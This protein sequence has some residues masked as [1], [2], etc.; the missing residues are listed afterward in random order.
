MVKPI[1]GLLDGFKYINGKLV[2]GVGPAKGKTQGPELDEI[3]NKQVSDYVDTAKGYESDA[4]WYKESGDE[5]NR[6]YSPN[7][8]ERMSHNIGI[9][10]AQNPLSNN[11]RMAVE[12]ENARQLG[13][14][15]GAGKFKDQIEKTKLINQNKFYTI[16]ANGNKVPVAQGNKIGPFT[17]TLV[18]NTRNSTEKYQGVRNDG[19]NLAQDD[20][21]R[22]VHDIWDIRALGDRKD[23]LTATEHTYAD[24]VTDKAVKLANERKLGGRSDWTREQLQASVWE[25]QRAK[26][27]AKRAGTNYANVLNDEYT[28]TIPV[29][30]QAGLKASVGERYFGKLD[31][32]QQKELLEAYKNAPN[33]MDGSFFKQK[34]Q[35]GSWRNGKGEIEN[36]LLGVRN[37]TGTS[38]KNTKELMEIQTAIDTHILNQDAIGAQYY[39]PVRAKTLNRKN[40]D[41]VRVENVGDISKDKMRQ[42]TELDTRLSQEYG[43]DSV[44]TVNP[45]EKESVRNIMFLH[46]DSK[47]Y[48]KNPEIAREINKILGGSED[49]TFVPTQIGG[50]NPENLINA[51]YMEQGEDSARYFYDENV[52][53]M[54]KNDEYVKTLKERVKYLTKIRD[55]LH[56]SNGQKI[57]PFKAQ[58]ERLFVRGGPKAVKKGIDKWKK[59]AGKL[60]S[61]QVAELG[62]KK[63]SALL[64][65]GAIP[66]AMAGEVTDN[67]LNARDEARER[68]KESGINLPSSDPTDRANALKEFGGDSVDFAQ[69]LIAG[70]P[71][72]FTGSAGEAEGLA[73]A[74]SGLLSGG[75][76]DW[77]KDLTFKDRLAMAGQAGMEGFD[78]TILPTITDMEGKFSNL[79]SDDFNKTIES[80]GGDWGRTGGQL[81]G[82]LVSG[83][84]L[85]KLM[86][87]G[88]KLTAKQLAQ[89]ERAKE[90]Q[91]IGQ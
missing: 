66:P 40:G 62:N 29:E 68:L 54:L 20:V 65:M 35:V 37:F 46:G 63:W 55:D 14:N 47:L 32:A 77:D 8:S 4:Y 53:P 82:E 57:N 38:G 56:K 31:D 90:M 34:D 73:R 60:D 17:D 18:R 16:D 58:A 83:G 3:I 9:S 23:A 30:T 13:R 69:G 1:T 11:T 24:I 50:K 86:K 39:N 44:F 61:T 6:R 88:V 2:G 49:L 48:R 74:V 75:F 25:G 64:A 85:Y 70:A 22:T 51:T 5:I 79:Y 72:G 28:G 36:N 21:S 26:E 33:T 76:Q 87:K 71:E 12:N 67:A 15:I 41:I 52:N 10:S 19:T 42:L 43:V 27:K 81:A 89:L 91:L 7:G 84:L 59:S 78:N 45:A 80:D